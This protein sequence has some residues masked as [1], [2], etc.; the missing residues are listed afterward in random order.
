MEQKQTN[1]KH[2]LWVMNM[3]E[4]DFATLIGVSRN[5]VMLWL[6]GERE[7]PETTHKLIQF[8]TRRPDMMNEFVC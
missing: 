6:K 4:Q 1:L 5:A 3:T 7:I 8:F 2:F